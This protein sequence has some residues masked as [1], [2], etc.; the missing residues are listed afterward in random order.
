MNLR[1][2]IPS[3]R[4]PRALWTSDGIGTL[5]IN[6]EFWGIPETT[7]PDP[8]PDPV[9]HKQSTVYHPGFSCAFSV[10]YSPV[11]INRDRS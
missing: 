2:T 9:S 1:E 7:P 4:F 8:D 3:Q 10:A 11:N 6:N 5:I